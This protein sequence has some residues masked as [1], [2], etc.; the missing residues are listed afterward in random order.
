R[1]RCGANLKHCARDAGEKADL[2]LLHISRHRP[3]PGTVSASTSR[4]VG[5]R[6]SVGP[7]ASRAPLDFSRRLRPHNS[8]AKRAARTMEAALQTELKR[9]DVRAAKSPANRAGLCLLRTT[10]L[11]KQTLLRRRGL[12]RERLERLVGLLGEIGDRKSTRLNSS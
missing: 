11:Y 10:L 8:G 9:P 3:R 1:G 4:D 2:R 6:G 12:H 7:P 5:A